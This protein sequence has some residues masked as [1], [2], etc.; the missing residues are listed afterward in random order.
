MVPS[1]PFL[2][3]HGSFVSITGELVDAETVEFGRRTPEAAMGD[4][5]PAR[6]GRVLLR[7]VDVVSMIASPAAIDPEYLRSPSRK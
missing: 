7:T 3:R 2:V 4:R 1:M 5:D 6:D